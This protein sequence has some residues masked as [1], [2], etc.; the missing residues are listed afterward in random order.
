ML[1]K[2]L[3]TS[4]RPADRFRQRS[5]RPAGHFRQTSV[6]PAG[7]FLQRSVRP[8]DRFHHRSVRRAGRFRQTSVRPAGRFRHRTVRPAGRF[9]QR[10]VRRAGRRLFARH[11]QQ[12][13]SFWLP[14]SH[15]KYFFFSE[16]LSSPVPRKQERSLPFP[17]ASYR[18]Q[19]PS[20]AA[21][22]PVHRRLPFFP[23]LQVPALQLPSMPL[24]PPVSFPAPQQ[25]PSADLQKRYFPAAGL[26]AVPS[27][28]VPETLLY[29][30]AQHPS[31]RPDVQ[32]PLNPTARFWA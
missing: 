22:Q 27:P 16:A 6:R 32:L 31:H 25:L 4:D 20:P 8:A 21:P 29:G 17:P 11:G 5:V 10:S 15:Q 19:E 18:K 23:L 30:P 12:L 3:Q 9:R 2:N 28:P 7:R 1:R 13:L 14:A 26:P 24:K